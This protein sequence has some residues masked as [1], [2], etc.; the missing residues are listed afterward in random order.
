MRYCLRDKWG[1]YTVIQLT[2]TSHVRPHHIVFS[3][4][5][6]LHSVNMN[7]QVPPHKTQVDITLIFSKA[8]TFQ[9]HVG[10]PYVQCQVLF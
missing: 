7:Q 5:L 10:I 3:P 2:L 1:P 9:I 8:V 6:P 4:S